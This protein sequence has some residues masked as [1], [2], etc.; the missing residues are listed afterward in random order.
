MRE[1]LWRRSTTHSRAL[2]RLAAVRAP[3]GEKFQ[4]R[5]LILS[6]AGYHL[7]WMETDTHLPEF[8]NCNGL[9]ASNITEFKPYRCGGS[10]EIG[11][12]VCA[13]NC[14]FTSARRPHAVGRPANNSIDN[15]RANN[16]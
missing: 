16:S 14:C 12:K 13:L 9:S 10:I 5:N 8:F 11:I 1:S 4:R 2:R 7:R 15:G 6:E 3:A